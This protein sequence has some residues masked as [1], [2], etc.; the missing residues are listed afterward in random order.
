MYCLA[1]FP[2]PGQ[3]ATWE[4]NTSSWR[5]SRQIA[6]KLL[7]NNLYFIAQM[8]AAAEATTTIAPRKVRSWEE[9]PRRAASVS[10][11]KKKPQCTEEENQ[12]SI[13]YSV[14]HKYLWP[15]ML[16]NLFFCVAFV[17]WCVWRL[18]H[19]VGRDC[20]RFEAAARNNVLELSYP[21]MTN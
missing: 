11:S 14:R 4:H 17:E 20:D 5:V 9:Q 18:L 6:F 19:R 12:F 8:A 10:F 15:W 1:F 16:M 7:A 13:H 21:S 3:R 2:A